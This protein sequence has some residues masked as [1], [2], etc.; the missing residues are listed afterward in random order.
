M[1]TS[2][3]PAP[4]VFA[5]MIRITMARSTGCP[6]RSRTPASIP[7][8]ASASPGLVGALLAGTRTKTVETRART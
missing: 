1:I 5:S 6:S 7:P 4:I 8:S 3:K 2:S